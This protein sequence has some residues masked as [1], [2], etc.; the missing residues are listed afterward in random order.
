MAYT[1]GATYMQA[2]LTWITTT[3]N[4][5]NGIGPPSG[6]GW[7][8]DA[9]TLEAQQFILGN[10]AG[11]STLQAV[12]SG[13]PSGTLGADIYV[14][15]FRLIPSSN[16]YIPIVSTLLAGQTIGTTAITYKVAPM[17]RPLFRSLRATNCTWTSGRTSRRIRITTRYRRY[18]C[19]TSRRTYQGKQ[20]MHWRNW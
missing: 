14:R 9:T 19:R 17:V 10:W 16:V 5:G 7:T 15:A 8:L 18:A 1:A 2:L 20:A 11:T 6:L 12:V 13:S 3:W 4:G